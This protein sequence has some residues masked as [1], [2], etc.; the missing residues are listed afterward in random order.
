MN[1]SNIYAATRNLISF[2]FFG[3]NRGNNSPATLK[4][5]NNINNTLNNIFPYRMHDVMITTTGGVPVSI[6]RLANGAGDCEGANCDCTL[7]KC[8]CGSPSCKWAG[9]KVDFNGSSIMNMSRTAPGVYSVIFDK[10]KMIGFE[11]NNIR[12]VGFFFAPV[13]IPGGSVTVVQVPTA[14]ANKSEYAITTYDAAGVIA[15]GVL[16]NTPVSI[17]IYF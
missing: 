10:T 2:S 16:V 8:D 15:D 13:A 7:Y 4:D 1:F 3:A 12:N 11:K 17:K 6:I 14:D 9:D 5:V